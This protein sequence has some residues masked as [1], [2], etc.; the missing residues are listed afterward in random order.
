MNYLRTPA[1]RSAPQI[2]FFIASRPKISRTSAIGSLPSKQ[3]VQDGHPSDKGVLGLSIERQPIVL[4]F[5][6]EIAAP[7]HRVQDYAAGFQPG[8]E[9]TVDVD[10]HL[11]SGLEQLRM[12]HCPGRVQVDRVRALDGV[13]TLFGGE[14]ELPLLA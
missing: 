10:V 9:L 3:L 13:E 14:L 12:G 4:Y 5:D 2:Y 8:H 7:L 6:G 11:A 1:L